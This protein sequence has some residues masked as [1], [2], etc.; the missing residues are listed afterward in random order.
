MVQTL[1]TATNRMIP[2][3]AWA[4]Q[5]DFSDGLCKPS[6]GRHDYGMDRVLVAHIVIVA[7]DDE[8]DLRQVRVLHRQGRRERRAAV[9]CSAASGV[10]TSRALAKAVG[11]QIMWRM[12]E[13][14]DAQPTSMV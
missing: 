10:S 5:S 4:V 3:T 9:R 14:I 2:C 13:R 6:P 11:P 12:T 8:I 1:L 7:D